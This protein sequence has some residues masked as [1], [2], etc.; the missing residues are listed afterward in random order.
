M[1]SVRF[2]LGRGKYYRMWQVKNLK[3]KSVAPV[4]YDPSKV[5]LDLNSCELVCNEN[6]ARKVYEAGVKDVC[7]WIKCRRLFLRDVG[8]NLYTFPENMSRILFNPIVDTSWKMEGYDFSINGWKFS[9][10]I[11]FGR[12][13]Y[14]PDFVSP[15]Y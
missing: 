1:Y 2:H 7:G 10:L 4:Y 14:S 6:K 8:S 13:V 12:R 11:T 15:T 3:D 9:Q 5:Q